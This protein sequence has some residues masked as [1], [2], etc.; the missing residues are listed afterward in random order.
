MAVIS[1]AGR[2]AYS[3]SKT[4]L[5]G[6]ARAQAIDLGPFGITVNCIAPGPFLT[7]LVARVFTDAQLAEVEAQTV[8]ERSASPHEIVGAA[9]LLASDAGSFITGVTLPVDGGMLCK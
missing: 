2:S 8:L 6:L 5:L 3:A 7:D 1:K 4:G 9:L